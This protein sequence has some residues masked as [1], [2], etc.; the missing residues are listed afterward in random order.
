M[1][2]QEGFLRNSGKEK[3]KRGHTE[4]DAFS[5]GIWYIYMKPR[6]VKTV[7]QI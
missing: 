5:L 4:R 2:Y 6:T 3:K 7:L 1:R